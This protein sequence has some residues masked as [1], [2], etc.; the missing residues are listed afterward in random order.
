MR[1]GALRR[2][3]AELAERGVIGI[4]GEFAPPW[5]AALP[6]GKPLGDRCAFT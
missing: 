4:Y 2:T 1:L 6:H 5:K 3:A